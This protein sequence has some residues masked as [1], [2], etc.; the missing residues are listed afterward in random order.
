MVAATSSLAPAGTFTSAW[1][2]LTDQPKELVW[3]SSLR[4]RASPPS[5]ARIDLGGDSLADLLIGRDGGGCRH[6]RQVD[7]QLAGRGRG[8]EGCCRELQLVVAG[9]HQADEE[10]GIRR[11]RLA[12]EPAGLRVVRRRNV[13]CAVAQAHA[14]QGASV[15][16]RQAFASRE[17]RQAIPVLVAFGRAR[18]LEPET[19]RE[20]ASDAGAVVGLL[21]GL[22]GERVEPGDRQV[23]APA[24]RDTGSQGHEVIAGQECRVVRDR[25]ADRRCSSLQQRRI[26]VGE[27]ER[28]SAIV[29]RLELDEDVLG[30]GEREAVDVRIGREGQTAAPPITHEHHL[31]VRFVVIRLSLGIGIRWA[32]RRQGQR[33]LAP[34]PGD[35]EAVFTGLQVH[36]ADGGAGVVRGGGSAGQSHAIA[37]DPGQQVDE[38]AGDVDL[39]ELRIPRDRDAVVI[40]VTR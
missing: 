20:G 19:C 1:S 2:K 34:S 25:F 16:Q 40:I 26:A 18:S 9:G 15:S 4:S 10:R 23:V 22:E 14:T 5:L 24:A 6:Q 8:L 32:Q 28:D 36:V 31:G 12:R 35:A 3:A 37:L 7:G 30:S 39:P 27:P 17:S 38:A 13:G 21:V 33:V 29:W 11:K